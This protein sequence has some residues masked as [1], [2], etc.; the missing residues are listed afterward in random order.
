MTHELYIQE[1]PDVY[2]T[3][4]VPDDRCNAALC[5]DGLSAWATVM[6]GNMPSGTFGHV[7]AEIAA[8]LG[9]DGTPEA[10]QKKAEALTDADYAQIDRAA[11]R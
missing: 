2:V 1:W 6:A 9:I 4:L 11:P 10:F 7:T 5:A 8:R 3:G